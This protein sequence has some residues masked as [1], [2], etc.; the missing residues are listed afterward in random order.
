MQKPISSLRLCELAELF[1]L[2]LVGNGDTLIDGVG[3]L[4]EATGSQLSFLSNPAYRD[5]LNS[6][7]AGVVIVSAKDAENCPVNALIADDPYVSY[8]R[9][10]QRFDP[11]R[12]IRPGL[13]SSATID[14]TAIIGRDVH[15][16]ANAVIG[17]GCVIEDACSIGPGCVLMADCKLGS[18][19]RLAA[20]V[21]ICEGVQIGRRTIIHPGAIIGSDGFGLAFDKNHWV[22]IPQIGSVQIGDDCEIGANTTIDRGAIGDTIIE[23]DVRLD[24]QI[25]IAHNV[26]VGAH[27]AM[28]AYVGISGS[29]KIGK[30]CMFGGRSGAVGHIR[31]AD[32]TTVTGS[33]PVTKSIT[34][35]GTTWSCIIPA[36]PIREWNRTIVHLRKL[37]KLA[38]RVLNL[39]KLSG[40]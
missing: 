26:E 4:S 35:P 27:T 6:T 22:K 37:E 20:N 8:A 25:Q 30:Y 24:N 14:P 31:I 1:N 13:H 19:S 36:Q 11:R 3:T 16:G 21:T 40:K 23:D 9:V 34:Q 18:S 10:V 12:P 7:Q 33:S 32:R 38:R 5:Q 39:E 17:P 15:V 2:R 29:T 28:A